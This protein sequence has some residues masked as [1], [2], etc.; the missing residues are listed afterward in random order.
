MDHN[1]PAD[2]IRI[3]PNNISMH[4]AV[5]Y[6][7]QWF[8]RSHRS[9]PADAV[10]H[11]L[12]PGNTYCARPFIGARFGQLLYSSTQYTKAFRREGCGHRACRARELDVTWRCYCRSTQNVQAIWGIP[13]ISYSGTTMHTGPRSRELAPVDAREARS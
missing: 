3:P 9:N 6:V 11:R 4:T 8:S 12:H 10:S 1:L 2:S 13:G 7:L 5:K